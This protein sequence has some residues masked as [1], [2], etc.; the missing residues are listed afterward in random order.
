MPDEDIA[1]EPEALVDP[2]DLPEVE[3]QDA[4]KLIDE[5]VPD[6]EQAGE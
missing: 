5:P 2:A 4:E 1:T 6:E 3:Q